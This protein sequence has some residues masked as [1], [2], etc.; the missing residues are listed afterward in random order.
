MRQGLNFDEIYSKKF[1]QWEASYSISELE[2]TWQNIKMDAHQARFPDNSGFQSFAKGKLKGTFSG[3][4]S[5]LMGTFSALILGSAALHISNSP[6]L[7]PEKSQTDFQPLQIKQP[8]LPEKS[9]YRQ[10]V[11]KNQAF[12]GQLTLKTRPGKHQSKKP[13]QKEASKSNSGV[14]E[15]DQSNNPSQE[16]VQAK[17][18]KRLSIGEEKS[19]K[20]QNSANTS[21]PNTSDFSKKR[22]PK[23]VVGSNTDFSNYPKVILSDTVWCQGEHVKL[24]KKHCKKEHQVW[25]KVGLSDSFHHL[26]TSPIALKNLAPETHLFLKLK[27]GKAQWLDTQVILRKPAP[28]ANFSYTI[29]NYHE[30]FFKDQS[31]EAIR[32]KWKLN[33]QLIGTGD[34]F[35]HQFSDFGRMEVEQKVVSSFGCLDSFTRDF[36]LEPPPS[37]KVPNVFTPNGDTKNDRFVIKIGKVKQFHLVIK[38]QK[39]EIVFETNQPE[40]CWNGRFQN[41]GP[42]CGAGYYGYLLQYQYPHQDHFKTKRGRLLLKVEK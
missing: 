4:K 40:K 32:I 10:P 26:S 9:P 23:I 6:E 1:N 7:S 35:R 37:V 8:Y 3:M 20:N 13:G 42:F 11:V 27:N 41:K 5:W 21:N 25:Y 2:Q 17:N 22:M 38:N 29:Q 28:K 16:P 34:E 30:V 15:E 24:R 33:G 14:G 31:R 18:S 36:Y 19:R 12:P 39:G